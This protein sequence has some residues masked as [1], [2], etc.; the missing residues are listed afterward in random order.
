M[1]DVFSLGLSTPMLE[2]AADII[3][4]TFGPVGKTELADVSDGLNVEAK[5]VSLLSTLSLL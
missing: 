3:G 1:L 4:E 5:T 2:V